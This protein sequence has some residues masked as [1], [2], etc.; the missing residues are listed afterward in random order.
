MRLNTRNFSRLSHEEVLTSVEESLDILEIKAIQITEN[1]CFIT[2]ETSEAKNKLICEGLNVRGTF[3]NIFDVDKIVTNVTI[4]DAPFELSD[5][6]LIHYMKSYG[7]VVEHSIKR[8]KIRGTEIETGTRYIQLVNCKDV[9]PVSAKFGRFKVRLFSDN[10]TEC[11]FCKDTGHPYYKCPE[12]NEQKKKCSRC[13]S[14]SHSAREC[15]NEIV[16]RFCDGEG[17]KQADCDEYKAAE[18]LKKHR[19]D[20]GKYAAEILEG[21]KNDDTFEI[22]DESTPK[23]NDVVKTISFDEDDEDKTQTLD[24]NATSDTSDINKT[25][26]TDKITETK[27]A[28]PAQVQSQKQSQ[29]GMSKTDTVYLVLGDSNTKRVHFKDSDVYDVSE[30]GSS[31]AQIGLLLDKA[32]SMTKNKF[33]KRIVIHL[34]TND[35]TRHRGDSDQVIEAVSSAVNKVKEKFPTSTIA[36]SSIL[37]RRGT[38]S[39]IVIMNSTAHAVN[40]HIYKLSLKDDK[41]YFLNNDEDMLDRGVP[42]KSLYDQ[43]DSKG[44]HVSSKGAETLEDN[45]MSFFGSGESSQYTDETP[46]SKKRN[47]SLLSLTPPSEKQLPKSL[48]GT[49]K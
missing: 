3:N 29:G 26:V 15:T 45:I 42:I 13:L 5:Q 20:Y 7:E 27:N 9:I 2:V 28:Q 43:S 31:A 24:K 38:T 1:A 16:C 19:D 23:Y 6:F 40:E 11:K 35:I 48:K 30:S 14:T 17:H 34:G 12:K 32:V 37:Q 33:V 22:R 46:A 8:G 41:L 18:T 44:V 47:R 4:K 49:K 39:G 25:N 10:K 21:R 36:F